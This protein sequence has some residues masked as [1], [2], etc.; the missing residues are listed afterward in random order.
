MTSSGKGQALE[1]DPRLSTEDNMRV[2]LRD[3][4]LPLFRRMRVFV[5]TFVLVFFAA[6]SFGLLRLHRYDHAGVYP[7]SS[8][9]QQDNQEALEDAETGLRASGATQEVSGPNEQ[10]IVKAGSQSLDEAEL[11]RE[12]KVD[13]QNYLL[14]LSKRAQERA[15]ALDAIAL[16]PAMPMLPAHSSASIFLFAFALAALVSF[17]TACIINYFDPFFH[18][19]AEVIECLG[20]P[21]V[22]AVP[23]W[24]A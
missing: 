2:R 5:S 16:P 7:S 6:A 20:I 24:T 23:K 10:G 1:M 18:T 19:P 13:E 15:S 12:V 22:V 17:P 14:Y 4:G 9:Q 3:L 11:E 21:V 8:P